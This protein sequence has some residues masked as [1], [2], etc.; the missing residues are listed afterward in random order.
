MNDLGE[1]DLSSKYC[2]N[3]ILG[4][5]T[6]TYGFGVG[7]KRLGNKEIPIGVCGFVLAY[8]D[9]C[10]KPGTPLTCTKNGYL[11]KIS[12]WRKIL[13]PEKIVATFI[14]N[15]NKELF[16]NKVKVNGRNWVKVR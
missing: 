5:A 14:K 11:T 13:N 9:K 4:I 16:A 12:W 15:E 10:Y 7:K 6:D 1:A 8:V 2:D 3:S